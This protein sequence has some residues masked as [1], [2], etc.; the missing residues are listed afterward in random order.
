[1]FFPNKK[2]R[3]TQNPSKNPSSENWG[4]FMLRIFGKASNY[5]EYFV[6]MCTKGL[7]EQKGQSRSTY[8]IAGEKFINGRTGGENNNGLPTDLL[9][10]CKNLKRWEP[11]EKMKD[12]IVELCSFTPLSINEIASL[13]GRKPF[14]VWYKY[15]KPLIESGKLFYTIPEMIKHPDQKY[16]TVK[17]K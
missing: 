6:F 12:L 8:Y 17:N 10:K 3:K 15:T 13:I 1:M 11:S 9:E 7:L 4:Y 5:W 14:S 2:Q 16:T